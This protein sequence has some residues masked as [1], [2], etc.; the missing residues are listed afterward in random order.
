MLHSP[1]LCVQS[2]IGQAVLFQ[3]RQDWCKIS[4]GIN[5]ETVHNYDSFLQKVCSKINREKW[6]FTHKRLQALDLTKQ[7]CEML[8]ANQSV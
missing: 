4:S 7:V 3:C 5:Q 2:V 8:G 6:L 1:F